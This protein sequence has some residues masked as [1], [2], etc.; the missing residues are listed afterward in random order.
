MPITGWM[1]RAA[2]VGLA[3]LVAE[4]SRIEGIERLRYTTSHPR[5]MTDDLIAAH[6]ENPKLMPYLHLPV[7]SGSDP[8]LKAM[9]RG[10]T[11]EH[12]LRLIEKIRAARPDMAISGDFIVGF[13]GETDEDFESTLSSGPGGRLRQRLFLQVFAPPRHAGRRA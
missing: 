1:H 12:Y 13:P 9:N 10:H 7:Q 5:D 6:A 3:G 11:A 8:I 4:L 2:A